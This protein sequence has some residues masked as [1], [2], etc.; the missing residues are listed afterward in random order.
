MIEKSAHELGA[1]NRG[2][3]WIEVSL[4]IVGGQENQGAD[5]IMFSETQHIPP[6]GVRRLVLRGQV[7]SE[8]EWQAT[9]VEPII[10]EL[11]DAG[12]FVMHFEDQLAV[13]GA[14][15]ESDRDA[16]T[17][18]ILFDTF[19]AVPLHDNLMKGL[20]SCSEEALVDFE[21][22][23]IVAN[24]NLD[25]CSAMTQSRWGNRCKVHSG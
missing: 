14:L 15:I 2:L 9:R 19:T 12:L 3:V 8:I 21:S 4:K 16:L 13:V 17:D 5:L 22:L 23:L 24:E 25:H 20:G 6:E 11:K 10:E 1:W 7:S 18:G